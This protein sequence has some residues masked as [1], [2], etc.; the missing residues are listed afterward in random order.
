MS[1]KVKVFEVSKIT[2]NTGPKT[3]RFQTFFKTVANEIH[4]L[5]KDVCDSSEFKEKLK[6]PL[7]EKARERLKLK[8]DV[9]IKIARNKLKRLENILMLTE[10]DHLEFDF[11]NHY[12]G[13]GLAI[14]DKLITSQININIPQFKEHEILES[15]A[16]RKG[17]LRLDLIKK[18]LKK[19][20][21]TK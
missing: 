14:K 15:E 2:H 7:S 1:P 18:V 16:I 5:E 3:E 4:T 17:I 13:T 10:E 19:Y 12:I 8:L 21:L 9:E 11:L 20:E 6:K